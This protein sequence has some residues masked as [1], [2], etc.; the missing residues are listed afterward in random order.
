MSH[1]APAALPD[2]WRV[3]VFRSQDRPDPDGEQTLAA[4]LELG[5]ELGLEPIE[6]LRL[7]RGY[8]LPPELSQAA[9]ET[10]ARELL[11][12]PVVDTPRITA[13]GGHPEVPAGVHRV[14]V[15]PQPGVM[16][17]VATAVGRALVRDGHLAE[18]STG[19]VA[20]FRAWELTGAVDRAGLET[21][22]RRLLANETIDTL[23]FDSEDLPYVQPGGSGHR[24]SV[25]VPLRALDDDALLALSR[26]GQLSL[27]LAEMQTVRDHYAA[28]GREPS[29]LELE[30]I[31][32]TW[33]EHCKHKTLCGLI[34][35]E[36]ERIDNL[37]RSTIGAATRTIDAPWCLS[38]FEDN[39]GIVE[40]E[41][42][43]A[44]CIKVETHNHPSAIDPFGGAGT[45]IG[46]VIR[47]VLGAGLGAE[48]IAN[49][50][51]FFVGPLDLPA[52]EVPKGT[53]HPRRILRGVV[54][55][56]RQYGNCMGIPTVTGGLWHH[57]GYTA[58]PLVYAGTVGL[59]P[60]SMAHKQV[61]A[62]DAIVAVGGRTGRDGIHGATFSSIELSEHSETE[63]SHAVQIGDPI[64]EK[65]VLDTLL[66]ARDAGLYRGITDCGAGGFSSAVG[67]MGEHCGADVELD[68]VPLKYPGLSS[69][70]VWI[71]EAQERMV[72]SVPPEKLEAC[73]AVFAAEDV[74]A[75]VIGHFTDTGKLVV[76]DGDEVVGELDMQ[77]LHKGN[78]RTVRQAAWVAPDVADPGV[79]TS[80]D[81]Q[82]ELLALLAHPNLCSREWI[83]R[84]YDHE[85]QGRS[86]IKPMVGPAGDGPGD[87]AVIQPLAESTRGLALA[88]GA[89][90]LQGRLD[91]WAM[92]AAG[93]DEA[94]RNVV[95]VGADP[96][97]A[98]LLDNFSWGNCN[99][100]DR[101]G[102][103]VL[104]ARACHDVA[105]A[106]RAPFV[107]GKDSLN[108]EYRVGDRTLSI[109]PTLLIT[110]MAPVPDLRRA[111]T[112]DL[113]RAGNRLYLVG[114]TAA[115]LGG[116]HWFD[117]LGLDGGRVPRPDLERAPAQ[118][119]ALHG[120]IAAGRVRACHDL[121]EGG[122]AVAAAE[123]AF[124]GR[125]GARVAL[126]S[127]PLA[128]DLPGAADG[129]AVAL[130]SE[131]C[132]RFLV[133]VEPD[134]AAGFEQAL[135]GFPC[136]SVGEV[137]DDGR[138]ELLGRD[139][140]T[141]VDLDVEQLR[142][143]H[144]G[145]FRG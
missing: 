118:M 122:L 97:R 95:S 30:T 71:S 81:P 105:L 52:D 116:S 112:M 96:E 114:E 94:L 54:D 115:D 63:S 32:Q 121:S 106:F 87:A 90:P 119:R 78:P 26:E 53:M 131:S 80:T 89:N 107:S 108:N 4:A 139:G 23:R 10:I 8:L 143:A 48:P 113:K 99:E 84:Q 59:M 64:T 60:S 7:G 130:F 42:D 5:L 38:V 92:A 45:G 16:D 29:A 9:V 69:H 110:A 2:A 3:E 79:P 43:Q 46:G 1:P 126:G 82:A 141:L 34:D 66:R 68:R 74:E 109:P 72:L 24:G 111:V 44:V 17:P 129:D 6:G 13:P 33:S 145:G 75:V 125:C 40:F 86:A 123:M 88:V 137:T 58:N 65:G 35:F 12:D 36:G 21:L 100:P 56:V 14:L 76:R 37:L 15:A 28:L 62:G 25:E 134:H 120:A 19:T 31:A 47:D 136:A 124:A 101:L 117:V 67:E 22:G 77:F 103:L 70:E 83:V 50:D 98:V 57:K 104:A 18:Y 20:T 128:A 41:G 140:A 51:A 55:G 27:D 133:E 138:L 132:T 91:P 142:Q 144:T 49:I 93:I 39:A 85:V 135:A 73:L 11:A 127:V 102:S 61:A